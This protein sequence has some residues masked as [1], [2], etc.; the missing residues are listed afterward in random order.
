MEDESFGMLPKKLFV[1]LMF[2]FCGINLS[3]I[4]QPVSRE[5]EGAFNPIGFI[6]PF[7]KLLMKF[8]CHLS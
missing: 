2:E 6:I 7:Y 5:S 8:L 3:I 1:S 4:I